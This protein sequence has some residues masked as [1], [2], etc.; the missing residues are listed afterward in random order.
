VVRDPVET[1]DSQL[2]AARTLLAEPSEYHA[3]LD[4]RYR[5]LL[6]RPLRF[7]LYRFL[8]G[9][10]R[11]VD[12]LTRSF[13]R[14]TRRWIED[15]ERQP[16]DRWIATRYEDLLADPGGELHRLF[17]FLRLPPEQ[18]DGVAGEIRPGA[19]AL[20]PHVVAREGQIRSRTRRFAEQFGY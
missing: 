20:D 13:V 7:A 17:A 4:L 11:F 10:P 9:R 18:V 2:Q 8:A 15:L 3:L 16:P 5:R 12:L 1:I 14:D 19:R 6:R